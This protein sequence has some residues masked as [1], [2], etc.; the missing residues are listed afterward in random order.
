[1]VK[2]YYEYLHNF[3]PGA[4][5]FIGL[6]VQSHVYFLPRLRRYII[7]VQE[8]CQKVPSAIAQTHI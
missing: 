2:I 3:L 4:Y 5:I 8:I 7:H 6:N 1:M